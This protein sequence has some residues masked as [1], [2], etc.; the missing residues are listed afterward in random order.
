M[1]VSVDDVAK[2]SLNS[3]SSTTATLSTTLDMSRGS[4]YV[5]VQAWDTK[6]KV[7][8]SPLTITVQ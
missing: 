3:F 7:Y 8:K 5:V 4:H 1:R 6:G 2:Y